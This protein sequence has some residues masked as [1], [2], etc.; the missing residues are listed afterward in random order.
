VACYLAVGT[1]EH[2][3]VYQTKE[4]EETMA[5]FVIS[6]VYAN[7]GCGSTEIA[8]KKSGIFL[9][10]DMMARGWQAIAYGSDSYICPLCQKNPPREAKVIYSINKKS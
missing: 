3:K 7:R 2:V 1:E 4:L 5:T 8:D 9:S 10:L 6:C